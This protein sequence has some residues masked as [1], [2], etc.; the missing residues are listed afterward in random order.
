MTK[1]HIKIKEE[2]LRQ[3]I[4]VAVEF[5]LLTCLKICYIVNLVLSKILEMEITIII[6][7]RHSI[8]TMI[9]AHNKELSLMN[10]KILWD[11]IVMKKVTGDLIPIILVKNMHNPLLIVH[12]PNKL[13]F[14]GLVC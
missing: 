10:L 2:D 1:N 7:T 13:F 8:I 9:Q 11:P 6:I 3:E 4:I 5:H 12:Y 14:K